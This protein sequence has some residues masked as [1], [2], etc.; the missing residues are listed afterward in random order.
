MR[1]TRTNPCLRVRQ[2]GRFAGA[3]ALLALAG[4]CA[5]TPIAVTTWEV[6]VLPV[7]FST[8]TT[9]FTGVD[10][11]LQFDLADHLTATQSIPAQAAEGAIR[12][13][14]NVL[15]L[16]GQLD[17]RSETAL[18]MTLRTQPRGD[19]VWDRAYPIPS[20]DGDDPRGV[21]LDQIARDVARAVRRLQ[22]ELP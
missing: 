11:G 9:G 3:L 21:L 17:R 7:D 15:Y 1:S 22:R 19:V 5:S 4:G 2:I 8:A 14:R 6:A 18:Q 12:S 20:A 10:R 16:G 13:D